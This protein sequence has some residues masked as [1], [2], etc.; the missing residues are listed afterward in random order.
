MEKIKFRLGELFCGPG[1]LAC[2]A[3][4]AGSV[5]NNGAEY[6]IQHAWATDYDAATCKTYSRNICGEDMSACLPQ[7]GA[8]GP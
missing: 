2:G 6:S 3:R 8:L 7:P 4:M 1:G 5:K